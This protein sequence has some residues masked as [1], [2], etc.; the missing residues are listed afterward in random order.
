MIVLSNFFIILLV[1]ISLS[2]DAFSLS[3][4]YGIYGLSIRNKILLSCIVG[5]FHFIMPIM[6]LFFGSIIMKYFIFSTNL[7]VGVIFFIIGI[8]MIISCF[9]DDNINI[10]VNLVGF[11]LFGMSVSVDSFT[12]GIGLSLINNNYLMVS[13]IFMIISG[14]LTYLGLS[15]GKIL[16][17]KFGNLSNL[18][19]G[20]IMIILSLYYVFIV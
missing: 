6:G 2:M 15:F 3:I 16:N 19:G 20:A 10:L 17:I 5:A 1:G 4:I 12:T 18:I 11:L 9:R 13:F 8:S 7:V 14:I